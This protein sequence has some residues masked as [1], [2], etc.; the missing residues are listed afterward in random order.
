M[1]LLD[2][3]IGTILANFHMCGIMLLLRAVDECESKRDYVF[4]VPDVY[5]VRILWVVIFTLF[6]CLLDLS[7]GECNVISLYFLCCSLNG[8]VCLVCYVFDSVCKLF[9]N[10]FGCGCYFSVECYGG[11]GLPN[12]VCVVPVIPVCI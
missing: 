9:R 8:S 11:V 6:Y 12:N 2:F 1:S 7:Y 3:G 10:I 5:F 4:Y